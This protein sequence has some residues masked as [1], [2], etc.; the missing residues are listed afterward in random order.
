MSTPTP[1]SKHPVNP[2]YRFDNELNF[3]TLNLAEVYDKTAV[4]KVI[5]GGVELATCKFKVCSVALGQGP[6]EETLKLVPI[7]ASPEVQK[8]DS[9]SADTEVRPSEERSD[10]LMSCPMLLYIR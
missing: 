9:S 4:F 10:E 7:S 5:Q 8:S 3:K 6:A 2:S 1:K